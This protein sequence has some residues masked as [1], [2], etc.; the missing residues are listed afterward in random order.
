[1]SW[2]RLLAAGK[3][4]VGLKDGVGR[5]RVRNRLPIFRRAEHPFRATTLPS[6]SAAE[7]AQAS[8]VGAGVK[9]GGEKPERSALPARENPGAIRRVAALLF[10]S[11]NKVV[12]E[13]R[14]CQPV[15]TELALDRVK[16]V[17]NDLSDE[18]VEIV[19]SRRAPKR[20]PEVV[21]GP[22]AREAGVKVEPAVERGAVLKC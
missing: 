6:R 1:M 16:V 18:D 5:Y 17:R 10:T 8:P 11:R 2:L 4:L 3:S 15:Q 14:L 9:P 22:A 7:P 13:S 20:A 21:P 19:R 12:F